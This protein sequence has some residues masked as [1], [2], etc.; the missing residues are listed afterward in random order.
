ARPEE[1][2]GDPRGV[3]PVLISTASE[4]KAEVAPLG[5][6]RPLM[7]LIARLPLT[8]ALLGLIVGLQ[9]PDKISH[10]GLISVFSHSRNLSIGRGVGPLPE[11]QL[12][13]GDVPH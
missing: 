4:G 13:I 3:A 8:P 2:S 10:A 9:D 5:R 11:P 7:T 12:E 6:H 1:A